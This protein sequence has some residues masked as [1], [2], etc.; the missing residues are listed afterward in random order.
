MAINSGDPISKEYIPIISEGLKYVCEYLAK[1]IARDGE[2]ANCLLEVIVKGAANKSDAI[3]IGRS[4][5]NSS[6]VKT[7][8]HGCDPNWGRILAAA[9]NAGIPF[10]LKKV[11]LFI[12]EYVILQKGKLINF[13]KGLIK[14]YMKL[15][16]NL[17][18]Y[19]IDNTLQIILDINN[20]LEEGKAW[21]CDFS[22]KY[23]EI[24]SEYTT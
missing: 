18:D 14:H 7:A 11:D 13:N 12:G 19:S 22:K 21:G 4:I 16:M 10:D 15:K 6:L 3:R 23:I 1:S 20:G 2:G 9:G 17:H 24:N 5:V 8:I